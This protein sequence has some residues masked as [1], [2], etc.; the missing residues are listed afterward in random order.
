MIHKS[1]ARALKDRAL[2][3]ADFLEN[4]AER[5]KAELKEHDMTFWA[6]KSDR[7]PMTLRKSLVAELL[8]E[9]EKHAKE[10]RAY[11]K[12]YPPKGRHPPHGF[13]P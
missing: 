10:L 1:T 3:A 8:I 9:M 4:F 7:I 13:S 12:E 6:Y 5:L 2:K 11:A